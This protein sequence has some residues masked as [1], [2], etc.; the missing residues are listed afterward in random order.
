[1]GKIAIKLLSNGIGVKKTSDKEG[2]RENPISETISNGF[3]TVD[4]MWT[5]KYWNKAA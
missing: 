3:F 2:Y 5:V 4:R 1:M